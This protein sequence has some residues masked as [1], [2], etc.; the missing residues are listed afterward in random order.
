MAEKHRLHPESVQ[1]K[2]EFC[3]TSQLHADCN[4]VLLLSQ[5]K[6]TQRFALLICHW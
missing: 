2:K 1:N 4:G 3:K 6:K 5:D